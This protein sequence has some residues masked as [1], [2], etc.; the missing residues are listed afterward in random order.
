MMEQYPEPSEWGD[1][2]V[3]VGYDGRYNSRRF[4]ELTAIVFLACNF[5]VF[6]Y[7]RTV[8]TPLIPY[9]VLRLNCLAGVMIT[10]SENPKQEN[11]YKASTLWSLVCLGLC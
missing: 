10:A 9:T 6:L 1:R 11:G 2:G 4:A 7:N 3:C 5:R 8:A